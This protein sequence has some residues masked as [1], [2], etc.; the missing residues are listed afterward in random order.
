[1]GEERVKNRMRGR[2]KGRESVY[3]KKDR[4]RRKR[5]ED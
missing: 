4:D 5:R 3:E 2:Q 1:M